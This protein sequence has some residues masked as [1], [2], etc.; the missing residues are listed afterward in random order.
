M[1]DATFARIF[2]IWRQYLFDFPK[3]CFG[4]VPLWNKLRGDIRYYLR[5]KEARDEVWWNSPGYKILQNRGYWTVKDAA[6]AVEVKAPREPPAAAKTPTQ[7][8]SAMSAQ[9][10]TAYLTILQAA[11]D[12]TLRALRSARRPRAVQYTSKT[13]MNALINGVYKRA[14]QAGK[15][16]RYTYP[17]NLVQEAINGRGYVYTT[18]RKASVIVPLSPYE[19]SYYQPTP[20]PTAPDPY[21][22]PLP[23]IFSDCYGYD[24][25]RS[26]RMIEMTGL[27]QFTTPVMPPGGTPISLT[28]ISAE[29]AARRFGFR[30]P[31]RRQIWMRPPPPPPPPPRPEPHHWLPP[32]NGSWPF[33]VP[34]PQPGYKPE[35]PKTDWPLVPPSV[36]VSPPS[37]VPPYWGPKPPPIKY[38]VAPLRPRR[39]RPYSRRRKYFTRRRIG[40]IPVFKLGG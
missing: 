6:K 1:S 13:R 16:R 3:L 12:D 35:P 11:I 36:P 7:M 24:P 26:D 33:P 37:T 14:N 18:G 30:Q 2:R 38:T 32:P 39:R 4:R 20:E 5:Y 9:D 29:E 28:P 34:E 10:R 31:Y 17:R 23:D 25:E 27:G 15:A 19:P 22:P 21:F 40:E 8:L